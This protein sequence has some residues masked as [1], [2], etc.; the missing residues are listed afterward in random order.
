M[1]LNHNTYFNNISFNNNHI[2]YKCKEYNHV[3]SQRKV[4]KDIYHTSK[5]YKSQAQHGCTNQEGGFIQE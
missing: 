5:M 1:E 3:I 4:N 2:D